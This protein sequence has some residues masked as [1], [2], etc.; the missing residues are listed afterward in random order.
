MSDHEK[1]PILDHG[2]C[3]LIES[4]GSDERVVEAARMSTG[5]GFR[6]WEPYH[7]C[8]E[9]GAWWL[10]TEHPPCEHSMQDWRYVPKGD[11]GLLGYLWTEEPK[12]TT[13]FEMAGMIVETA[14]P[15]CVIWEWVRHRT[16]SY[17]IQSS[18]YGPIPDKDYVPTITRLMMGNDGKNKQAGSVN[19]TQLTEANAE[20]FQLRLKDSYAEQQDLYERS[21]ADGVPKELARLALTFGRYW[22][23]RASANLLNWLKFVT[24]RS[25]KK[26]QWEIRQYS[27]QVGRVLGYLFPRT[28]QLFVGGLK[29]GDYPF[30]Q[31]V[32]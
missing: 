29:V 11:A 17:N 15:T 3:Q 6:T 23:M 5:K 30:L 19:G 7:E 27:D 31:E 1:V 20:L 24:L 2:Y 16:Q 22:R 10:A 8:T 14:D 13:P 18:R 12:H 4:W 26:A 21:L 32:S 25:H 28:W 9:C